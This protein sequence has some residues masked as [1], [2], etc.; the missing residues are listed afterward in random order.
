MIDQVRRF[1]A[2]TVVVLLLSTGSSAWGEGGVTPQMAARSIPDTAVTG[3]ERALLEKRAQRVKAVME[4]QNRHARRLMALPEVVGT[5]TGLDEAGEPVIQV[6]ARKGVAPGAVPA[7][8]DG[9]PVAV[10]VTGEL[11]ALKRPVGSG[12]GGFSNTAV[13]TPPVPIG[14][15]T[16]NSLQCSA[17]TLGARVKDQQGVVFALSNNHVYAPENKVSSATG[18]LQPGL[19]DT[20]CVV[21]GNKLLGTLADVVP[22]A[23]NNISCDPATNPLACNVV[24]A[25]IA[26][27]DSYTDGGVSLPMIGN[28]TPPAGYGI[29]GSDPFVSDDPSLLIRQAVQKYGRTTSL[30]KGIITGVNA[31]VLVSYGPGKDALFINQII[32]SSN[33]PFSKAGDSGSLIVTNNTAAQPV[34]LLFAGGN[35]TTIAN[36]IVSVLESF[37]V[38]ID[39]K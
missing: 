33:K 36:P 18:I 26:T 22:I 17:G 16:G 37:N 25:A 38:T 32:I 1:M 6:F 15:S 9:V 2:S 3:E 20:Q 27:I 5:A 4:T 29:P 23:F 24:D 34:G 7:T 8:I 11:T 30:T 10:Q 14:V 35:L 28:S 39:G 12:G 19:Y 13:L 31:S 21:S